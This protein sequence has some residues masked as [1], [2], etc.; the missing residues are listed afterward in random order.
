MSSKNKFINMKSSAFVIAVAV[1]IFIWML[2]ALFLPG[3]SSTTSENTNIVVESFFIAM[4]IIPPLG[5][6]YGIYK[7]FFFRK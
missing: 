7:L 3:T 6:L 2:F 4:M 1:S 5:I